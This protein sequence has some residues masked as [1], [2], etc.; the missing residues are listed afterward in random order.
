MKLQESGEMYLESILRLS[1]ND[2]NVRS[3]DVA[4]YMGF[5]KPSVSRAMNLL[6]NGG[7]ITI[8]ECGHIALTD[9]GARI[10]IKIYDRHVV[11]SRLLMDLGVSR[12]TATED[13][14]RMEHIISDESF[15]AICNHMEKD[16]PAMLK[17]AEEAE[18]GEGLVDL[19]RRLGLI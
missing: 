17:D 8:D 7:Y 5:S 14:C 15:Q 6:K 3:V 16:H 9:E 13:A 18:I 4:D 12:E 19:K 10:A 2:Q 1:L 11:L